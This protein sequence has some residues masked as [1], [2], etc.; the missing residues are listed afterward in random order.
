MPPPS[1]TPLTPR[2]QEVAEL[3]ATGR[4]D[5]QIAAALGISTRR[6]RQIVRAIAAAWKLERSGNVRVQIARRAA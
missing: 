2:Q 3:I 1:A 6:V 4:T 5:K